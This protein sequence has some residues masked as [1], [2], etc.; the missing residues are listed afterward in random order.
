[1]FKRKIKIKERGARYSVFS[2]LILNDEDLVDF[3]NV[4]ELGK[5]AFDYYDY[6]GYFMD[7]KFDYDFYQSITRDFENSKYNVDNQVMISELS[8]YCGKY[9]NIKILEIVDFSTPW[10]DNIVYR[11]TYI[12]E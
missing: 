7:I 3:I 1:M 12:G 2:A 4:C 8:S 9:V 5:T 6:P 11:F 10:E